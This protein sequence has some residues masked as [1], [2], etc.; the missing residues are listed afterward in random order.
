[1]WKASVVFL[2]GI[3]VKVVD[4]IFFCKKSNILFHGYLGIPSGN[5]L[6]LYSYASNNHSFACDLYW[7]GSRENKGV[8][9]IEHW[10]PTPNRHDSLYVHIQYLLF[11]MQFKVIIVESAGD[12]SL[13]LRFLSKRSRLKVL[14]PHGFCLKGS[15]ILAPNLDAGQ[16]KIWEEV[17]SRFDLISVSSQLEKYMVSATVNASPHDCVV[18]GPQR[19]LGRQSTSFQGRAESRRILE[20]VYSVSLANT[21][22]VIVYA[23]T[24]RDHVIEHQR[25]VEFG[26]EDLTRL[27]QEL[28]RARATLFIREH[29]LSSRNAFGSHSNIVFTS[30]SESIDFELIWQGVDALVTDYSGIFLEYLVSPIKLAFWQYDL[31]EYELA[32]GLSLNRSI[33]E[34]GAQIKRPQDFIEFLALTEASKDTLAAREFW[35]KLLY[36]LST[37]QALLATAEEINR[38]AG[39]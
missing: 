26:F 13:Y 18:M 38:R 28:L 9:K 37:E 25:P 34:V 33:F 5:N 19:A 17:G 24:H 10:R 2:I 22:Q 23:P 4:V 16:L 11:L 12:L 30:H 20:S 35:H 32:R 7:T 21:E 6:A 3:V 31:D 15:G 8:A 27:N 39:L 14:L 36:E 29:G 1:M